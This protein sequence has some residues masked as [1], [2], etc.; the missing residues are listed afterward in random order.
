MKVSDI[1]TELDDLET[2]RD[3]INTV[4]VEASFGEPKIILQ[5]ELENYQKKVDTFLDAEFEPISTVIYISATPTPLTIDVDGTQQLS[6]IAT[7]SNGQTKDV[8]APKVPMMLFRDFDKLTNNVGVMTS[9]DISGYVGEELTFDIIKTSNGFDVDDNKDTQGL[10]IIATVN[11]NEFEIVDKSG[12]SLGV[13]FVT[14]GAHATGDNWLIDIYW[15]NTGTIYST[16]NPEV[17]EVNESGLVTAL[18]GGTANI[19]VVNGLQNV[20]IP[21][22]VADVI[23]PEPPSILSITALEEGAEIQYDPSTSPDAATYNIYVD[24]V[25][26]VTGVVY[27]GSPVTIA[28]VPADGMISYS[29]TMTTVDNSGN[30]SA[31]SNAVAVVPVAAPAT[32]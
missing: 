28:L 27:D 25:Q 4:L 16:D 14:N 20:S 15:V 9:V 31:P 8:T 6:V 13:K 21:I 29:I 26:S 30:E 32:P 3:E 2:K 17:A 7:L 5:R 19:I 18:G 22:T 24:G 11:P 1:V 23:A 12:V 10:Q